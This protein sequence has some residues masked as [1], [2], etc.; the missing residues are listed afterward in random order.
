MECAVTTCTHTTKYIQYG[1]QEGCVFN[2]TEDASYDEYV[3]EVV[4]SPTRLKI[5]CMPDEPDKI[6]NGKKS[7]NQGMS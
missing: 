2:Q 1:S 4:D 7:T 6:H 5:E 3:K